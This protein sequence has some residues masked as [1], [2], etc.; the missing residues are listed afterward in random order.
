[1]AIGFKQGQSTSIPQYPVL[2][3]MLFT[4]YVLI[5]SLSISTQEYKR[6]SH[7]PVYDIFPNSSLH[8][9]PINF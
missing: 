8:Q 7:L 1:M 2:A 9:S 3:R 6:I 5:T 4:K